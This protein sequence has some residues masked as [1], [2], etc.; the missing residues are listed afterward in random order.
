MMYD[1]CIFIDIEICD[2]LIY[3][4]HVYINIICH[5]IIIYNIL[6]KM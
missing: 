6:Q 2:I 5:Y 3:M 1:M 4:Y